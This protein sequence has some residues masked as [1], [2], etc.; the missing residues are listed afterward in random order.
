MSEGKAKGQVLLLGCGMCAPPLVKYLDKHGIAVTVASR[1]LDKTN[2]VIAGLELA[3]ATIL[4]VEVEGGWEV[5]DGLT[6]S[7]DLVVS[8]LPYIHHV[9]AAKI[10]LKY[11]KHF[12]TTSYIS[13]EMEALGEEAK[14]KGLLL[15]NE[16]G[17]DPGMDHMSAMKIIDEVRSKGGKILSFT[18]I[19]GGLPAPKDNNNPMGYKLSWSPR[20]VL[21]AGRNEATFYRNGETVKAVGPILYDPS[22]YMLDKINGIE[23]EWY[24]NRDS[25]KYAKI[26]DIPECKTL[27]RGTFRNRGWCKCL[28]FLAKFG[29]NSTD[30]EEFKGC[31]MNDFTVSRLGGQKGENAREEAKAR[32]ADEDIMKQLEWMGLF[33]TTTVNPKVTCALDVMCKLWEERMVYEKGEQDMILMKHT[34]EV[35]WADRP[36]KRET[37]TSTLIDLGLQNKGGYSSMSRTVSLPVAI[38]VRHLFEG[39]LKARGLVRPTGSDVYNLVLKEM[40][41][42]GVVFIEKREPTCFWMRHEV[43]P[44]EER[45]P[46]P[47]KAAKDLIQAGV[48]MVVERSPTRCFKDE[49]YANVGCELVAAGSW[50]NVGYAPIVL[51]LKELPEDGSRRMRHIFFAH[52]YKEQGDWKE[53]MTPFVKERGLIWDLEFLVDDQGRRVAAF[54]RPAGQVGMALAILRWCHNQLGQDTPALKSWGTVDNMIKAIKATLADAQKKA[55]RLPNAMVLGALG[56]C[57]DGACMVAEQCGLTEITR[58]DMAET[59]KGPPFPELQE[60]DLLVNAIYL[61]GPIKGGAF[62]DMPQI[63]A[64]G[65]ARKLSVFVDVSCDL[66]N[67]YNPFPLDKKGNTL[68]KPVTRLVQADVKSGMQ[69]LDFIGIDHLPSLVP[70]DSSVNFNEALQPFLKALGAPDGSGPDHPVWKRAEDTFYTHAKKL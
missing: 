19:C 60:H 6:Q 9:Q 28:A 35:E 44:G 22:V 4:D 45:T 18:S 14:E 11:N 21:L 50:K 1:T 69:P 68:F 5:L 59:A 16:C 37:I 34:F 27:I 24:P 62:L 56:R 67:P 8:L 15:L 43:K 23:Y 38:C 63:E 42:E 7:T 61:T 48:K 46:V 25:T 53:T 30:T 26:Y 64:K 66:S 55:G 54:G 17:V 32:G 2:K 57:G 10:A 3:K 70:V 58:W 40:E 20:G 33:G 41:T 29:F 52:C 31:S 51:G 47:P 13:D 65:A 36:A 12:C 49:E 39:T